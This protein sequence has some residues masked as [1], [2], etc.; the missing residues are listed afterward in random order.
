MRS[1]EKL[2]SLPRETIDPESLYFLNEM[3]ENETK[4]SKIHSHLDELKKSELTRV[5]FEFLKRDYARRFNVSHEEIVSIIVGEDNVANEITKLRRES[6]VILIIDIF[7][8]DFYSF[9]IFICNH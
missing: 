9:L 3:R 1:I 5:S 2:V 8:H 6:K 4:L 7:I